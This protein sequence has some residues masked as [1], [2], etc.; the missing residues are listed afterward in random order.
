[1][2]MTGKHRARGLRDRG[3]QEVLE[4][5]LAHRRRGDIAADLRRNFDPDVVVLTSEG[6]LRG[7]DGVRLGRAVAHRPSGRHR[8]SMRAV[9]RYGQVEWRTDRPDGRVTGVETFIIR[10]GRVVVHALRTT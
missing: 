1:M 10:N 3:A 6:I 7:H 2:T 9:G 8:V 4:D 5:H